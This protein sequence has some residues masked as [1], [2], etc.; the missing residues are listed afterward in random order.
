VSQYSHKV[1]NSEMRIIFWSAIWLWLFIAWL[2]CVKFNFFFQPCDY[3]CLWH[4]CFVLICV[5]FEDDCLLDVVLCS[6]I[7]ID[8]HFRGAYCLHFQHDDGGS[9]HLRNI[10]QFLSDYMAQCPRRQSSSYS[11]PWEPEMSP[12]FALSV[13]KMKNIREGL[14]YCRH[15]RW[16]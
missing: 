3:N 2:V 16:K 9:K 7:E 15:S 13:H 5:C 4:G 10:I 8:L 11:L 14:Q 1:S 6:L 12:V